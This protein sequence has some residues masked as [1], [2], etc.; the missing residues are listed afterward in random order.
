VLIA[1][2]PQI[3]KHRQQLA[4]ASDPRLCLSYR[5]VLGACPFTAC[6]ETGRGPSPTRQLGCAAVA[7]PTN[8]VM[9]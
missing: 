9:V 5:P 2:N 8:L 6:C 3:L 1:R 7:G 4:S